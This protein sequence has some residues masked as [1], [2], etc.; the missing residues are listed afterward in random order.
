VNAKI[1]GANGVATGIQ[2]TTRDISER[3]KA[4]QSIRESE[5]RYRKTFEGL[6]DM[7]YQTDAQG[8]ITMMS[9]SCLRHTGYTPAELVGEPVGSLFADS[10]R[11]TEIVSALA[12]TDTLNDQEA[13][14]RRS[15]GG[16]APVSVNATALRDADGAVIGY[17]GT[18]RDIT[19]RKHAEEELDRVFNLTVD[20]L[21]VVAPGGALLRVNPAWEATL[22]Y[23]EGELLG[24]IVWSFVHADDLAETRRSARAIDRGEVVKDLRGRF[25]CK[26]GS[27]KWLGWSMTRAE[28]TED[29]YC[30]ARDVSELMHA[31]ELTRRA[32]EDLEETLEAMRASQAVLEE[33][34]EA[35]D[36][37][38]IEAEHL[39]N[40]DML[41]G[42]VNR[43]AWFAQATAQK[44]TAIAIFDIDY[45]KRVNDSHGH[46]AGD[47]VLIEVGRRLQAALPAGALL[48]RLGGEEFGAL[49]LGSFSEARAASQAAVRAI[50]DAPFELPDGSPLAISVSGGLAPWRP[51]GQSRERSLANTYEDA[52]AA[53]Y[54]AKAA[55][56]RTL[57]VRGA[58]RAA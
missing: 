28:G 12:H 20:L 38:R 41:T 37:M 26:D 9:P 11:F 56:R 7:F 47:S 33:Q 51:A 32:Q 55:G 52:D 15:D 8:L 53:L 42:V 50:A 13:T 27:W 45:F 23:A 34:A 40:H 14:L 43:R 31:E 44:P 24:H 17:E 39:A 35:M 21:A 18:L 4:E 48:G 22:G 6:H 36:Q 30:V 46:P 19:E 29:I 16:I 54:E 58:R 49:F 3:R 25:R 2:G 10:D 5:E 1:I 57:A